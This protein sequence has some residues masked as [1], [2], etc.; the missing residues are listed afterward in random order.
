MIAILQPEDFAAF[1]TF[2]LHTLAEFWGK[3]VV[4]WFG[5]LTHLEFYRR[6]VPPT[7][8]TRVAIHE[9]DSSVT[10]PA[11][12]AAA[13]DLL[14]ID[15]GH[16]YESVR[17]DGENAIRLLRPGGFLVFNDYT[18]FDQITGSPYGVV[19]AVNEIVK[20]HSFKV[21]GFALEPNMFCDIALRR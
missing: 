18:C 8:R 4:E 5:G 17:R 11:H 15:A 3:P 10:L 14:Y 20:E 2:T 16:D 13:F 9:G 21:V 19:Q 6:A 1:D 12:S 7:E